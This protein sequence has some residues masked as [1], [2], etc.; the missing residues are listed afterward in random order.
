[1]TGSS[2]MTPPSSGKTT[3]CK[4]GDERKGGEG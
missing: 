4:G 2:S 3:A 1:M